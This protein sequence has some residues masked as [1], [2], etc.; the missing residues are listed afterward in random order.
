MLYPHNPQ[1]KPDISEQHS[2]RLCSWNSLLW[3]SRI[4]HLARYPPTLWHVGLENIIISGILIKQTRKM[5]P[6]SRVFNTGCA[7]I[8]RPSLTACSMVLTMFVDESVK[9]AARFATYAYKDNVNN[10][11][12]KMKHKMFICNKWKYWQ[13]WV[14]TET[15][16]RIKKPNPNIRILFGRE[17]SLSWSTPALQNH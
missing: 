13:K 5:L 11:W 14:I 10:I 17:V 1:L 9:N 6:D 16:M 2:R 12:V 3:D 4:W 7:H 15:A 8:V